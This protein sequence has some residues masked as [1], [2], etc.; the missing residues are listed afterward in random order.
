[1]MDKKIP[2]YM[3]V[4]EQLLLAINRMVVGKNRLPTEISLVEKLG[5]TRSTLRE[6][7]NQLAL[8]KVIKKIPGKGMVAFPSV[9]RLSFRMDN[10]ADFRMLLEKSGTVHIE[11]TDIAIQEPSKRMLRRM[12]E[13]EGKKVYTWVRKHYLNDQLVIY[14][15]FEIP[16]DNFTKSSIDEKEMPFA[17]YL[18]EYVT[19]DIAYHISWIK[20]R[21]DSE[22]AEAFGSQD[23][24][25]ESWDQVF[26][27]HK[28]ESVC[29]CQL[30]FHPDI[31]DLSIVIAP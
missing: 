6:A 4:K 31:I 27:D 17:D 18:K 2:L 9:N 23:D 24:I 14:A 22:L 26:K 8:E 20:S 21:R 28:D 19:Q 15:Y 10:Y 1:M 29:F 5:V 25:I 12:P 7:I 11:S 3:K 16:V 30:S 13:A